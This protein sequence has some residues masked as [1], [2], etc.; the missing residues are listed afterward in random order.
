MAKQ[1]VYI[2]PMNTAFARAMELSTYA[3]LA[4][5]IVFGILYLLGF[6]GF[7]DMKQAIANW[8]LPVSE[9]WKEV[10]GIEIHGY[11]W[12][13]SHLTSMDALSMVGVC[14][15]SLAPLLG[16]VAALFRSGG[17]KAFTIFYIILII[18]FAFAILK[19]II[20]PG[21]GGH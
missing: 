19:P 3:G 1:E 17:Q 20:L 2:D 13:L 15:L 9:F 14:I 11:S 12:F 8:H 18:E 16:L 4:V 21:V 5:M 7:V 10:K 6:S